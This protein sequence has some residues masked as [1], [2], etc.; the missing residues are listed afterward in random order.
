[1]DLRTL[2]KTTPHNI[3]ILASADIITPK[4]FL[5]YLPRTHEDRRIV[6]TLFELDTNTKQTIKAQITSKSRIKTS[7]WWIWRAAF[8]D[9]SWSKWEIVIFNVWFMF[10]KIKEDQ[11]YEITGKP[12]IWNKKITFSHPELKEISEPENSQ[13]HEI[14]RIVPIYSQIWEITSA[15]FE[16]KMADMIWYADELISENLEPYILSDYQ[17]ISKQD[18]I[19]NLHFPTDVDQLAQA[20]YRMMFEK[21][22][23]I[24][25]S[26]LRAK[27]TYQSRVHDQHEIAR[28]RVSAIVKTLPFELTMA[29]KKCVT[30]I[31]QDMWKAVPMMRLLQ[32]DVW[33]GKTIV[34]LI[35]ARYA[36][37]SWWQ[38]AFLAPLEVLAVQ[39]Y[40]TISKI[41][42]AHGLK[43]ELLTWSIPDSKKIRI[44]QQLID[45][46]I[47]IIIGTHAI[48]Q[49][50]VHFKNLTLAVIDEQ[51]KFGVKQRSYLAQSWSPHLLQMTATPIPRSLALAYFGEFEV[52]VIDQMPA[53]RKPIYTKVVTHAE[54][55]KIKPRCE[56]KLSQWQSMFVVV[57][58]IQESE[59]LDWVSSAYQMYEEISWL[60]SDRKVWL[61]HGKLKSNEK[62]DIMKQF[63][64]WALHI[65]V[66]TTVIEVGIDVPHATLMIIANAERFGLSQ[67]HQ[68]RWRV[69]RSDVQS[70]CFLLT[71]KKSDRLKAMEETTDWFKLAE[72]DLKLRW[73]WELLGIRQSGETDI[74]I[75]LLSDT[76]FIERVQQCARELLEHDP[77]L[78]RNTIDGIWWVW[79]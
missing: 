68:L 75:E 49:D 7:K 78:V 14:W 46:T 57:P 26:S 15:W 53:W 58:L 24:Q 34:A 32:W 60:Y 29:Q 13:V 20:K 35:A 51:H 33:S 27:N 59:Q 64:S 10:I 43:V 17:L 77:D 22:L 70:Y 69:G 37:Q 4:D 45:W 61:L 30:Q 25:I 11:W 63:V 16:R 23:A 19:R 54:L 6:S 28:D 41:V 48:I 9:E 31:I 50:D 40:Q 5:M 42:M 3:A 2:L 55:S 36:T 39:H 66:S 76:A 18:M 72:I 38:A 12:T 65:L 62:Q 74:P 56:H 21:I 79:S 67:L 44:K 52:S 47:D 8:I 71:T 1:M 73:P